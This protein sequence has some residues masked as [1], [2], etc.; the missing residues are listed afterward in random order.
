MQLIC[1]LRMSKFLKIFLIFCLGYYLCLSLPAL[2]VE[3]VQENAKAYIVVDG[4]ELF[5]IT[6]L[7][8]LTAQ[9]RADRL[10]QVLKQQV[11]SQSPIE[12]KA[13]SLDG[14]VVIRN[15]FNNLD[16]F[17]LTFKDV[18]NFQAQASNWQDILQNAIVRG[19][20]ERS[21]SYWRELLPIILGAFL[22]G[23]TLHLGTQLLRPLGSR[24]IVRWLPNNLIWQKKL[25]LFWQFFLGIFQASIWV[26][27]FFYLSEV[28]PD[29][30]HWRYQLFNL[31]GSRIFNLGTSS[32]SALELLLLLGLTIGLWFIVKIFT[33][34]IKSYF[35]SKISTDKGI[36]EIIGI[37]IQYILAFL[38]SIVLWQLW[39][40]DIRALAIIG[41]F[42]GVGIGFG[43]QNI[44]NN[45]L[46][47]V[48]IT[49]ERSIQVGD[50]INVGNLVGTVQKIGARSIEIRTLDRVSIV[51]PNSRFLENEVINWNHGDPVSRLHVPI[52][53]A[54][55]SDVKRVKVAL[56]EAA[57][58][59][60]EVLKSPRPQ[61][62]LKKFDDST[63]NFE[64]LVWTKEPKH[65]F[66]LISDLNYRIE[67]SL[68][69]YGV[70][71]P[72]PQRD[73]NL[74][75]PS[76][77]KILTAF[78]LEKQ[79]QWEE[80]KT[81]SF[82]DERQLSPIPS[83]EFLERELLDCLE[84][85]FTQEEIDNLIGM[86]RSPQGVE[87]KDRRYR[88][89]IYTACFI[90]S[91]AVDWLVK[92]Y[93][94]TREEAVELGQLLLEKGILYHVVDRE[95]FRDG[96]FFYRFDRDRAEI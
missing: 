41:S 4:Q 65:Q 2:S 11:L 6:N 88:L 44:A 63:L 92:Y 34:L 84:E 47:G 45:L 5:K 90:G 46:S 26:V 91:E 33:G 39:G 20:K 53:V 23:I 15:R 69:R 12:L 96:Y 40:L 19:K 35:L 85:R 73:V 17:S 77:E 13:I 58:N 32:Y 48:I 76:L 62:W 28:L 67:E 49:L 50:F 75:S 29:L 25:K 3:R 21:F 78:L 22:G 30:R 83:D 79:G 60:P 42:L 16:L 86:M 66:R 55:G 70:N 71:I 57:K 27:F 24:Q 94:C 36:Q 81:S 61:V 10:N 37:L 68:R 82:D 64:L 7:D 56:L 54:Y 18:T 52:G 31:L 87:I 43:L 38:G 1:Q 59:H 93:K 80:T 14:K 74:R 51:V 72:F 9:E 89:N 95:P 8:N